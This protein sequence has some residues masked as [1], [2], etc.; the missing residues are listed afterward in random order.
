MTASLIG[1]RTECEKAVRRGF[2]WDGSRVVPVKVV[3]KPRYRRA[4]RDWRV[5]FEVA[6]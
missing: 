1:S 5:D 6:A 2:I 4:G 3:G